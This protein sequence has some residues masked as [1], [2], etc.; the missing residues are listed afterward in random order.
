MYKP[1]KINQLI[2]ITEMYSFFE[3]QFGKDYSFPGE[4]HNFWECMYVED[5]SVCVSGD[6]R[7][8][9]LKSGEI[10]FHKPMEF[11]KFQ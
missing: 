11:H 5:G 4:S 8:Y 10:I 2:N 9:S 6:E 3:R 1:Y 7:V